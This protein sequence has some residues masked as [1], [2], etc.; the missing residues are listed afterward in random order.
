MRYQEKLIKIRILLYKLVD[1]D[2][3]PTYEKLIV[4]ASK[5]DV[6]DALDEEEG[7]VEEQTQSQRVEVLETELKPLFDLEAK[8]EKLLEDLNNQT[9]DDSSDLVKAFLRD[10]VTIKEKITDTE[11]IKH[12][13]RAIKLIELSKDT[14]TNLTKISIKAA[15]NYVKAL[16]GDNKIAGAQIP[17]GGNA[18]QNLLYYN[19]LIRLG[20]NITKVGNNIPKQQVIS[21][22]N[23]TTW[24]YG[25]IIAYYA[26]D[27]A[28]THRTYGHTQIYIGSIK[29]IIS[30]SANKRDSLWATSVSNNYGN[31]F[32]YGNRNSNK[33]DFYIFRAPSA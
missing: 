29:G 19:N 23:S 24:G 5:Y 16:R 25:D 9:D 15:L 12:F 14:E 8:I 20:Y 11:L 6:S 2:L 26:N 13:N 1:K 7:E 32:V 22:I 18:N 31:A 17:A 4:S 3:L 27:G 30:T 33:W 28:G 10:S 21:L